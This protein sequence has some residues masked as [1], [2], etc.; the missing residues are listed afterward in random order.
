MVGLNRFVS[1]QAHAV[2]SLADRRIKDHAQVKNKAR[3]VK[4][5]HRLWDRCILPKL[6]KR[7]VADRMK[8]PA[9]GSWEAN[10]RPEVCSMRPKS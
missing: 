7:K 5:P 6:G 10:R 2:A 4:Q 9:S 1:Q 8:R 3:S